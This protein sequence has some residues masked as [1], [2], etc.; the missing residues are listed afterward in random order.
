MENTRFVNKGIVK[1][2]AR[3]LL[4]GKPVYTDD[5]APADCLIVKLLRSPHAHAL[6]KEIKTDIALK[7]PGIEAVFT[8]KDVPKDRFTEAGQTFP[9]PSPDDRLILDQR[10]RFVGDPVAIVA[11]KDEESVDRALKMIKVTYQVLEPILD[12]TKAKDNPIIIH[13]EDNYVAKNGQGTDPLRNLCAS[14]C[15]GEGD[16][17]R[18]FAECEYQVEEVYHT[19]AVNQAMMEPFCAFTT[20]DIYG[21]IKTIMGK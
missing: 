15:R 14:Q 7:V 2:D 19:K 17:D 18:V 20:K 8:Y 16:V 1:K 3:A 12:F 5:I 9:E 6:I 13:P 11:G 4:S 10:V 21:R